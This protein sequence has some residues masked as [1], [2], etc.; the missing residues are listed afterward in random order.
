MKRLSQ[1]A[2]GFAAVITFEAAAQSTPPPFPIDGKIVIEPT[3]VMDVDNREK[4]REMVGLQELKVKFVSRHGTTYE[5]GAVKLELTVPYFQDTSDQRR[6]ALYELHNEL[7]RLE[8][9]GFRLDRLPEQAR[10]R[11]IMSSETMPA[12]LNDLV[13]R[14]VRGQV[15]FGNGYAAQLRKNGATGEYV[16]LNVLTPRGKQLPPP[17][18]SEGWKTAQ[19]FLRGRPMI[20]LSLPELEFALDGLKSVAKPEHS[21]YSLR[22]AAIFADQLAAQMQQF[23]E[24]QTLLLNEGL[25]DPS[26]KDEYWQNRTRLETLEKMISKYR[27]FTSK[28]LRM[29]CQV[30][31]TRSI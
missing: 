27:M 11:Y 24:Q 23:L 15:G 28:T 5:L 30:I 22:R 6:G 29:R 16:S 18:P 26:L 10:I 12:F 25:D 8:A 3:Q 20:D 14:A 2:I 21:L 1:I 31:L 4:S 7:S 9:D 13:K 17:V 19:M